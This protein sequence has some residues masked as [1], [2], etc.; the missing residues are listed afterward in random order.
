[1]GNVNIRP[2]EA[3]EGGGL[4]D[5]FDGEITDMRFIMTDFNGKVQ[6]AVPV[7]RVVYGV[8]GEEYDDLLSVGGKNDFAPDES[9][10]GLNKLGSKAVLTKTCNYVVFIN[11]LVESG[12]PLNKLDEGDV[13]SVI[14]VKGH[15]LRKVIDH[16]FKKKKDGDR[17]DTVM[18]CTKVLTLP[19]KGGTAV[20]TRT[21][22]KA[23]VAANPELAETVAIIIQGVVIENDGNVAKKSLMSALF[24]S[25]DMKSL[26]SD[27]TAAMKLASSDAFLKEREEWTYED[28]LLKMV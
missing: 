18:V 14:G 23:K 28:G 6:E 4:I 21:R 9:G 16:G 25:A 27:K 3:A 12:F 8:E 17:P 20:K 5:D 24:K 13:S 15:F 26:G 11:S 22:T 10:R 7:C 1:M 19:G 2:D